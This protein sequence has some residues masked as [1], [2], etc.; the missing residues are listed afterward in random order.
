MR[1]ATIPHHAALPRCGVYILTDGRETYVGQSTE[2][3]RRILE[4]AH[5]RFPDAHPLWCIVHYVHPRDLKAAEAWFIET[6]AP[7][8]NRDKPPAPERAPKFSFAAAFEMRPTPAIPGADGLSPEDRARAIR[9]K[10]WGADG[11]PQPALSARRKQ[12]AAK[13]WQDARIFRPARGF[14]PTLRNGDIRSR[15]GS[16]HVYDNGQQVAF[17]LF[18]D[19]WRYGLAAR[20]DEQRTPVRNQTAARHVAKRRLTGFRVSRP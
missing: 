4:S 7:S 17:P 10:V 12:L 19:A 6:V 1:F 14:K 11:R 20:Y 18:C 5:A 3:G 15:Q 2:L 9:G 16:W 8:L 13:R